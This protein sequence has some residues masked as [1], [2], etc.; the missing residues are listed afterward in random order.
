MRVAV[1]QEFNCLNFVTVVEKLADYEYFPFFG[2][3][4]GITRE[5]NIIKNDD[6]IDFAVACCHRQD[7]INAFHGSPINIDLEAVVNKSPYFLQGNRIIDGVETYIDFYFYETSTNSK[8]LIERWNFSGD[9]ENPNNAIHIPAD[10]IYPIQKKIFLNSKTNMPFSPELCCEYLYGS[11]WRIPKSKDRDYKTSIVNNKPT[12]TQRS[13]FE[14]C[15]ISI[16][17]IRH[18]ITYSI[19]SINVK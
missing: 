5:N 6:D 19:R 15:L 18:R 13:L 1:N 12:Q 9:W 16:R 2:T 11:E 10:L 8:F 17:N 7:V 3:L 14:K 4:L